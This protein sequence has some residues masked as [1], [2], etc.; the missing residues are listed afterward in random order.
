ML[1]RSKIPKQLG[2]ILGNH[3]LKSFIDQGLLKSDSGNLNLKKQIAKKFQFIKYSNSKIFSL[4]R[5]K[6][7]IIFDIDF[8]DLSVNCQTGL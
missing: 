2:Y 1:F 5:F 3:V 4:I 6:E 7:F 8:C